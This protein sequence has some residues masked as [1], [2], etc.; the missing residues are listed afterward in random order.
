MLVKAKKGKFLL[1][2]KTTK[3]HRSRRRRILFRIL[4][5]RSLEIRMHLLKIN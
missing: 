4:E 2:S 1:I 3:H 5:E